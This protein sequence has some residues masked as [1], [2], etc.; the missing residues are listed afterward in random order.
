VTKMQLSKATEQNGSRKTRMASAEKW[1]LAH[2][3]PKGRDIRISLF[4]IFIRHIRCSWQ[5]LDYSSNYPHPVDWISWKCFSISHIWS[6]P[7]L[8]RTIFSEQK[9]TADFVTFDIDSE[10]QFII[11]SSSSCWLNFIQAQFVFTWS[12]AFLQNLFYHFLTSTQHCRKY[13]VKGKQ[14][15]INMTLPLCLNIIE[16][17]FTFFNTWSIPSSR[18]FCSGNRFLTCTTDFGISSFLDANP[19]C[20]MNVSVYVKMAQTRLYHRARII[21][22]DSI[23]VSDLEDLLPW[24][25]LPICRISQNSHRER[26]KWKSALLNCDHNKS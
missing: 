14:I 12:S 2:R 4:S 19:K 25:F 23:D 7:F 13:S 22:V 17:I 24:R 6:C 5:K 26:T 18:N 3:L 16:M 10:K 20:D 9:I 15:L 11:K 8:T 21:W 1:R